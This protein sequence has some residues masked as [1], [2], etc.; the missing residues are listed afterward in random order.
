MSNNFHN[1]PIQNFLCKWFVKMYATVSTRRERAPSAV[2]TYNMLN[3]PVFGNICS[4]LCLYG[5]QQASR[6]YEANLRHRSKFPH[7]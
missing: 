2:S 6:T 7:V 5:L 4:F 1:T 3:M